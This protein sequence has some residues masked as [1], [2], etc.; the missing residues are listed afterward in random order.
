ITNPALTWQ[1]IAP[2][3]AELSPPPDFGIPALKMGRLSETDASPSPKPCNASPLEPGIP[4]THENTSAEEERHREAWGQPLRPPPEIA[5][6]RLPVEIWT[7]V[8]EALRRLDLIDSMKPHGLGPQVYPDMRRMTTNI[9]RP[10]PIITARSILRLSQTCRY[11]H[12]VSSSSLMKYIRVSPLWSFPARESGY[13]SAIRQTKS[14]HLNNNQSL[15]QVRGFAVDIPTQFIL[16]DGETIDEAELRSQI[17]GLLMRLPNLRHL[18]VIG[19]ALDTPLM[20]RISTMPLEHLGLRT[21]GLDFLTFFRFIPTTEPRIKLRSLVVYDISSEDV[22]SVPASWM[23]QLIGPTMQDLAL[24]GS[25]LDLLDLPILPDLE[26]LEIPDSFHVHQISPSLVSGLLS[27]VPNLKEVAL[28]LPAEL[29]HPFNIFPELSHLQRIV[30]HS[31]WLRYLVPARP[32]TT[33]EV[34]C[35]PLVRV[36]EVSEILNE[37]SVPLRNL[38]LI[39]I[40]V[41]S[42]QAWSPDD[43]ESV[44]RNAPELETL[45]LRMPHARI[46]SLQQALAYVARLDKLRFISF[47]FPVTLVDR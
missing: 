15:Q 12:R 25:F 5:V 28:E 23:S 34:I 7:D 37:G 41:G 47:N 11:L 22:V 42:H 43:L 4:L 40:E 30:C 6:R 36:E 14:L 1:A 44:V 32:I 10:D 35:D 19:I 2:T 38:S 13:R 31:S 16:R 27:R 39:Y 8:C 46:A 17:H 29:Q 3:K 45:R 18:T 24:D 20:W 21:L 33:A 9:N 26:S